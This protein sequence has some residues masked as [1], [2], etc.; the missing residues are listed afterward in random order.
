MRYIIAYCLNN[1][2]YSNNTKNMLLEFKKSYINSNNLD[3][4][5]INVNQ[6]ESEKNFLKKKYNHNTFPIVL[7]KSD[8]NKDYLLGG[9]Q[10][11]INVFDKLST[12]NIQKLKDIKINSLNKNYTNSSI[13]EYKILKWLYINKSNNNVN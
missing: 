2:P 3:I 1:C 11:L 9:N 5:I 10:E 12:L 7:Y 13:A 6:I 8:D 4:Q